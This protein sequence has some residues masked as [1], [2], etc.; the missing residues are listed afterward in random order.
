MDALSLPRRFFG[1]RNAGA[2]PDNSGLDHE[3]RFW[4]KGFLKL[5]G[6]LYGLLW[7]FLT[8]TL[9]AENAYIQSALLAALL[10]FICS[11]LFTLLFAVPIITVTRWRRGAV[12]AEEKL[13]AVVFLMALLFIFPL[14]WISG[15]GWPTALALALLAYQALALLARYSRFREQLLGRNQSALFPEQSKRR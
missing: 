11:L 10:A 4:G 15:F 14:C 3:R 9:T 7:L 12:Q 13:L 5:W 6:A 1:H 8:L 2:A